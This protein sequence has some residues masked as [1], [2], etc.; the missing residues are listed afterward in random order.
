VSDDV[1]IQSLFNETAKLLA[2]EG[3][4]VQALE[5]PQFEDLYNDEATPAPEDVRLWPL[6]FDSLA[7]ILHSSGTS[8]FPKPIRMPHRQFFSFGAVTCACATPRSSPFV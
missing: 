2:Q 3:F 5:V 6:D 8:S 7:L 1:P 4:T